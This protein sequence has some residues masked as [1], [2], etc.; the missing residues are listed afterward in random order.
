MPVISVCSPKGGVGKTTV[1]ANLAYAFSRAGTKVV[2]ID[3]DPQNALRLYFGMSLNDER[4]FVSI[5]DKDWIS[6][7]INVDKNL[8]MLPFGKSDKEQRQVLDD[9]LKTPDYFRTVQKSLFNN[10][11]LLVIADFA[12]GYTQ[13]LESIASVSNMQI[14]PLLADAASVSLFSQLLA[15]GLMDGL[16]GGG[17]G[18]YIILNQIDN[19]IKLNR[20]V[21]SF[22]IKNFKDNLL[23]MI[24]RDTSVTE[25]AGQQ[26]SVYDYNKNSA[27]AFDIEVIA[28]KVASILGFDVKK[29]TMIINPLRKQNEEGIK[30]KHPYLTFFFLI[31]IALPVLV[32]VIVAPMS[33]HNQFIIGLSMI[34]AC[35][36]AHF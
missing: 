34:G 7:C 19:R 5:P 11:D 36:I 23:G 15:G 31:A 18:Y 1:V 24:H 12:P 28:R 8:Y 22:A 30:M 17:L 3:F 13:A 4:G 26:I 29:G 6:A 21:Q 10:P 32:L 9:A 27:A 35:L 16:V 33:A 2:V 20:E 25:A 14:V